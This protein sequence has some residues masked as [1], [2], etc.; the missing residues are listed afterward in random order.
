MPPTQQPQQ[1][2][3]QQPYAAPP[4]QQWGPPPVPPRPPAKKTSPLTV[5][6]V[7]A[8]VLVLAVI[9]TVAKVAT[10][11][12]PAPKA[13]ATAAAVPSPDAEQRAAYL[14]ALERI[15]PGLVANEDRAIRRASR[16]CE[17]IHNPAGGMSL[18][19]YTV[20]EL[21]GGNAS[22][23]TAQARQVIKAVK[24]WCPAP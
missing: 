23:T 20:E 2:P 1:W 10:E 18:E 7:V 9:A 12:A 3:P 17:R 4:P 19:R 8:A 14:A 11:D 6:I 15:D 5:V 13:S 24:A 21:S 16:V 22:I